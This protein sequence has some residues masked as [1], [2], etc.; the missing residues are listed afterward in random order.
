MYELTLCKLVDFPEAS[1]LFPGKKPS[2]RT[3]QRWRKKGWI[4]INPVTGLVD[5]TETK[6]RLSSVWKG[7][8]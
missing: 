1:G 2:S 8:R 7:K 5:I 4:K 6:R 3:M